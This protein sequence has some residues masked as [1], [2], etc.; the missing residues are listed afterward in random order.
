[1]KYLAVSFQSAR[2]ASLVAWFAVAACVLGWSSLSVASPTASASEADVPQ[3]VSTVDN[4]VNIN[5]ADA[6]TLALA[7]DGVGSTRAEDIIAYREQHGDFESIEALAQVRGIG[8]A[9]LERNRERIM[10]TDPVE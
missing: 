10:L 8:P 1:M 6:A 2:K 9:T 7:L 4:R 5:T 3:A